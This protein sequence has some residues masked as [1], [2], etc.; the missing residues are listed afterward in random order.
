MGK[1]PTTTEVYRSLCGNL[2]TL[3]SITVIPRRLNPGK[4]PSFLVLYKYSIKTITVL[5]LKDVLFPKDSELKHKIKGEEKDNE[6]V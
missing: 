5:E 2:P 3:I 1:T 4:R 6:T